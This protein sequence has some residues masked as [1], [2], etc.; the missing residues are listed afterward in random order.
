MAYRSRRSNSKGEPYRLSDRHSILLAQWI[1]ADCA[2]GN[3]VHLNVPQWLKALG[4]F[5]RD[6][7]VV[8][9]PVDDNMDEL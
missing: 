4:V 5:S 9:R 1:S 7:T 2:V 3:Q 8:F 6:V